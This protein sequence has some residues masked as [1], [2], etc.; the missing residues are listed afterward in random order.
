MPEGEWVVSNEG[1]ALRVNGEEV[2]RGVLRPGDLVEPVP[3]L[4]LRF[5]L[6]V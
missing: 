1:F 4:Q 5:E 3:G 2:T 6:P